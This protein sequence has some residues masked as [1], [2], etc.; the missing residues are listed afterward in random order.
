[1]VLTLLPI[2]VC[3]QVKFEGNKRAVWEET[4]VAASTGLNHIYV[5]YTTVG[6]TMNYD[7]QSAST[8]VK[9]YKYGA[10][11]GGYAEEISGIVKTG[12]TTTLNTIIPN[13]GYI[14]EEGT[15]RTYIW[16]ADYSN[17]YLHLNAIAPASEQDCGSTMLNVAGSGD[18]IVYYTINGIP[19]KLSRD[20]SMT[21][22]TLEWDNDKATWVNTPSETILE[23]FKSAISVVA[24][25][26]NTSF[27]LHGDR[28]LN[29][30]G[31]GQTITSD[32]VPANAVDVRTTAT[33]VEKS[34]TNEITSSDQ[35]SLG[36]SAPIT[37]KFTAYPTD[38][39]TQ[40]EW[41]LASDANFTTVITS[42]NVLETEQTFNEAGTFYMRFIGKNAVGTCDV[43][44][45]TYTINIGESSLVCPNAFSPQTSSGVN[46][47]WKV[48][49][50]S[51]VS[52]K[53]WI[54]NRW[55]VQVCELNDPSQG[56]DGRYKGKYVPTG[57]YYYVIQARG[58]DGRE[59]KLKGDINII[60]FKDNGKTTT[61]GGE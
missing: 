33:Q 20:I 14:I 1:M 45:D 46:D 36:G 35:T 30:W 47:E 3:A 40:N 19:K 28:F 39:L 10:Q 5:L 13:S 4:S 9:W 37:I 44:S 25:L 8:T 50:K 11:G 27:T 22:N 38:A 54:F 59:Y 26:C 24:P 55:G 60:G 49:Y 17:Y 52:F 23:G 21:Y 29:F 16:V 32:E 57:V 42:L 15:N 7:A 61:N 41:Q 18:D 31:E 2:V 56:W 48:I 51:I 58:A 43:T 12:I 53:C 34:N 6:V